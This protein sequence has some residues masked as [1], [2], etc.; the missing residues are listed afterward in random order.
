MT[1]VK[2]MDASFESDLISNNDN[3]SSIMTFPENSVRR[4]HSISVVISVSISTELFIATAAPLCTR[5]I[6]EG[7]GHI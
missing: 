2:T 7:S 4:H 5:A 6:L 1:D 3:S